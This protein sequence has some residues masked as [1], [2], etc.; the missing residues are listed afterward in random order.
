[1]SRHQHHRHHTSS[2][3]SSSPNEL[4]DIPDI[5]DYNDPPVAEKPRPAAVSEKSDKKY[6]SEWADPRV[7]HHY[8]VDSVDLYSSSPQGKKSS[9]GKREQEEHAPANRTQGQE[10]QQSPYLTIS[11]KPPHMTPL[12]I[13]EFMFREVDRRGNGIIPHAQLIQALRSHPD[14]TKVSSSSHQACC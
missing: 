6:V 10:R 4:D 7:R 14:Q 12:Q 1:V 9:P 8:P 11:Q 5:S 2:H 13:G 3:R